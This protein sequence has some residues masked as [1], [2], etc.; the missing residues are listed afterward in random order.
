MQILGPLIASLVEGSLSERQNAAQI[1]ALHI[2]ALEQ[3]IDGLERRIDAAIELYF[4]RQEDDMSES[5]ILNVTQVAKTL[6]ISR[7]TVYKLIQSGA[8]PARKF[9]SSEDAD[10]RTVVLSE[11]LRAFLANLPSAEGQPT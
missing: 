2:G 7:T 1:L 10:P 3:R 6:G 11:D 8:L 9:A 5:L 4:G